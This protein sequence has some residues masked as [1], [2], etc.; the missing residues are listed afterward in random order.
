MI[1]VKFAEKKDIKELVERLRIHME[2]TLDCEWGG[3]I[4]AFERDGFGKEFNSVIA[5]TQGD[6]I[7]GFAVWRPSYDVHR[8]INFIFHTTN[9]LNFKH[10]LLRWF[11][12]CLYT[13]GLSLPCFALD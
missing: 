5:E 4:S 6:K 13:I 1:N 12:L 7:M 10:R 3:S 2:E 11:L 8:M 9:I